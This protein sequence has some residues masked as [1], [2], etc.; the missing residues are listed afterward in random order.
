LWQYKEPISAET[1]SAAQLQF[2]AQ[3]QHPGSTIWFIKEIPNGCLYHFQMSSFVIRR[4]LS[5]TASGLLLNM[6][7][8]TLFVVVQWKNGWGMEA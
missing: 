8:A 5:L 2:S 3:Y 6:A 7:G 4:R 1:A